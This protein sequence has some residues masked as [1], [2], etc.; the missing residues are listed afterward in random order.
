LAVL[1]IFALFIWLQ[2]SG[3]AQ[4][5]FATLQEALWPPLL[6]FA[7]AVT[8]AFVLAS[9]GILIFLPLRLLQKARERPK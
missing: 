9:L 5:T 8:T 7:T 4:A 3:D 2:V 6:K 1:L